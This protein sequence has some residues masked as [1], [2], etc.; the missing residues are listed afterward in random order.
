MPSPFP[1]MD[2][3]LENP[4]LWPDVHASFIAVIRELLTPNIGPRYVARVEQR[5]FLFEQDD[6]AS[7]LYVV[8]DA[9]IIESSQRQMQEGPLLGGGTATATKPSV[10]EEVDVTGQLNH[11]ARERFIEI[12]DTSSREVVTVI[13]ILSPS[14]KVNGS[15][16]RRSFLQKREDVSHSNTSWL[17]IDLLRK[18]TPTF[19]FSGVRRSAYRAYVDRTV[20]DGRHQGVYPIRL[21]ERLPG[22][23]VP[24]RPDDA[25]VILD[26]QAMLD[27]VYD[28]AAYHLDTDYAKQSKP[29]LDADDAAWSDALLREKKVIS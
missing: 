7:E 27:L 4:D 14:N 6:P 3:Y 12:R 16:G 28:R 22:L 5:A 29:P 8:P 19:N 20:K 15:A 25:D 17:E 24:L 1:G 26:L 2:P 11:W 18:G 10:A 23:P 13:E 21:R 9:R